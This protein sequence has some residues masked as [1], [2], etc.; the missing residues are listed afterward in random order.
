MNE[1]HVYYFEVA[2]YIVWKEEEKTFCLQSDH[3]SAY[4]VLTLVS[5]PLCLL[6]HFKILPPS[7][8][9]F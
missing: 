8:V 4:I 3:L 9:T 7:L 5:A 1:E 2:I 6:C